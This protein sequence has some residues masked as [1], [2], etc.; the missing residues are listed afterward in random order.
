M[1]KLISIITVNFHQDEATQQMIESLE[2]SAYSHYEVILI[3]NDQTENR[4]SLFHTSGK[5][6][7]RNLVNNEGFAHA[8]NVGARISSG[9]LLFFLNNDT[10]VHENTLSELVHFIEDNPMT[11]GVSPVI[12]YYD[13]PDL[14]QYAGFSKINSITGRNKRYYKV[15]GVNTS[16]L[17]GAAMMLTREAWEL[18]GPMNTDYFLYYEE[19]D[20]SQKLLNK[21][22]QLKVVPKSRILHKA[23]LSTGRQSP[24]RHYYM[25]R[26]RILWM[27]S[28]SKKI[29]LFY[30]YLFLVAIPKSLII[31][32]LIFIKVQRMAIMDA[33]KHGILGKRGH[34]Y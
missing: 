16:Y 5:L 6:I 9:N 26:N 27:R 22:F 7:Y 15:V 19:L 21:G 1:K 12:H 10:I 28:W 24:L 23:S 33:V 18:T 20:L 8:C 14:I 30:L 3:D 13:Q 29:V 11:G 25:M 4:S 2:S 34:V 31:E 17:H 32:K